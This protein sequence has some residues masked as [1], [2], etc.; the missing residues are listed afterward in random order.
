MLPAMA[1]GLCGAPHA[2]DQPLAAALEQPRAAAVR[3]LPGVEI[4][5]DLLTSSD[6]R[7]DR[8]GWKASSPGS[9]GN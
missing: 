4:N 7:A 3:P 5:Y 9:T 8:L 1:Y 6:V 2:S